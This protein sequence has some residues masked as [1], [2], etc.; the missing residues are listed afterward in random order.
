MDLSV[1]IN[2]KPATVFLPKVIEYNGTFELKQILKE[3]EIEKWNNKIDIPFSSINKEGVF[4]G[5]M[6]SLDGQSIYYDFMEF[7]IN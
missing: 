2:K 1:I 3:N 4:Y 5:C 7:S 6:P